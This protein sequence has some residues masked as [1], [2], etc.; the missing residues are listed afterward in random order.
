VTQSPVVTRTAR[1]PTRTPTGPPTPRPYTNQPRAPFPTITYTDTAI[2]SLDGIW[3]G[4]L[5]QGANIRRGPGV[6][7]AVDRN[8]PQG[9]RVLVYTTTLALNGEAWYQVGHYPDPTLYIHSSLV[10]FVAPLAVPVQKASGRWIDVNLTQQTLIA[11]VDNRPVL[12]AQTASG[13]PGHETNVGTWRIY[14][15]TPKQDMDGGGVLPNDPYYNLK[16]VPW[17]QYFYNSGEG[18]HGTYWHDLF[19]RPRSHGCVNVS[20]QNANWLYL[21]ATLGTPVIVHE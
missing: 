3:L 2:S 16:D 10:K 5:T 8:W 20:I 9:R 12:L 11:Y 15:R 13:K 7:F 19:G 18:I 17:V 6:T 1:P 14:W 4:E 21:W